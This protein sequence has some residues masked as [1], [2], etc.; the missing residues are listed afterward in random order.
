MLMIGY[1]SW[2]TVASVEARRF[3]KSP[4][5]AGWA[6]QPGEKVRVDEKCLPRLPGPYGNAGVYL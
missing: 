4:Y 1:V 2:L 5:K 3:T 6:R